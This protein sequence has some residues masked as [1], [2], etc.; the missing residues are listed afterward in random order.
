[1]NA[2]V[3][4]LLVCHAIASGILAL[5]GLHRL[6]LATAFLRLRPDRPLDPVPP[7]SAAAVPPLVT[8]QIP[9]YNERYVAERVIRAA[10]ALEYPADRLELQILDDSTDDTPEIVARVLE[11]LGDNPIRIRHLRRTGR[12]G[13]KAGALAHGLHMADGEFIAVFDADFVPPAD[14]LTRAMPAFAEARVGMV[15]ARWGHLNESMS[16]LTRVQALQLDA[17]FTV[18]HG[19]RAAHGLFFNFNGTAAVWRRAAI[20]GAGGWQAD[21]LT[22]D[23]D[24][25]YRAQLAGWRFRYVDALAVP[26][27]LPVEVAAYRAQQQRWAQGGIQTAVKLLPSILRAPISYA[28]KRSAVAHLLIHLSYPLLVFVTLAGF[29]AASLGG[30]GGLRWVL[31]IDGTLLT[32]AMVSLSTFYGVA[33]RARRPADWRR[34]VLLVVPIMVLG[35]GISLAQSA[36]V[37][38]GLMGIRTPFRRTPKYDLGPA[39]GGAWRAAAYRRGPRAFAR[40]E[41][42]AGMALVL[43]A[44]TFASQHHAPP[45]GLVFLLGGGMIAVG[46][47]ELL[48]RPRRRSRTRWPLDSP[49]GRDAS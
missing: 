24:L 36:A 22:E 26:A 14:F 18:E 49:A 16:W 48:Q 35:A 44:V 40:V 33:A 42:G 45:S 31:V 28:I 25:S 38:R 47:T 7:R 37:I 21:T 34:R 29:A 8:V 32:F 10:A 20:D 23:L 5:F 27:E 19:V 6:L 17:H 9:L 11:T 13:F 43:S 12:E 46:L 1:M 30:V 41:V 2:W 39:S 3:I 4:A 15:Q